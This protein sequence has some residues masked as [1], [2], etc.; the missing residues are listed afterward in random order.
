M[1]CSEETSGTTWPGLH[2]APSGWETLFELDGSPEGKVGG[3]LFKVGS[4]LS[5][6]GLCTNGNISRQCH[7]SPSCPERKAPLVLGDLVRGAIL[8][9]CVY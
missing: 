4:L 5:T 1:V 7:S 8:E 3:N 6:Q 9:V 2:D